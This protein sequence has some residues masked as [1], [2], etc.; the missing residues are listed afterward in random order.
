MD[1]YYDERL[2]LLRL[3][4]AT[5]EF[6]P[7]APDAQDDPDLYHVESSQRLA[8]RGGEAIALAAPGPRA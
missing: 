3:D 8:L 4:A 2:A 1:K 6:L 5:L 7:F